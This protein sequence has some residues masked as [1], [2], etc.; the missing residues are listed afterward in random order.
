MKSSQSFAAMQ[1]SQS[2]SSAASTP[3]K[4]PTNGLFQ[5]GVWKCNC[6]PRLPAVQFTVKKDTVNR[7]R[8]FYTCQQDRNKGNQC[9][10]FLWT[11][12]ARLREEGAVLSNSRNEVG[13]LS[14]KPMKQSTLHEAIS[15]RKDKRS[16]KERTPI[17]PFGELESGPAAAPPGTRSTIQSSATMRASDPSAQ[18]DDET[19]SDDEQADI[20]HI[21]NIQPSA[22]QKAEAVGSKRKRPDEEDEYS[23]FS[24]G[25]EEELASIANS[26]SQ[27]PGSQCKHRDALATPSAVRSVGMQDGMPTPLTEKPVRRVLFADPE[28][29]SNP[30]RQRTEAGF[31]HPSSSPASTPSSSQQQEPGTPGMDSANLPTEIMGLL[32]DQNIEV[33]VLRAVRSSLEKHAATAKGLQ[34]GRDASREAVKKAEGRIAQLQQRVADLENTRKMMRS[35]LLQVYSES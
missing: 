27:H 2:A 3:T 5:N 11:E 15:P 21:T 22:T 34:R 8:T 31:T 29:S 9:D 18:E 4:I 33:S 25:A 12:D 1:S 28:V 14:R 16:W 13:T 26:S 6:Q 23:D 30:K 17:T 19:S 20:S 35:Q 32:K 24:S 10:L 7:G